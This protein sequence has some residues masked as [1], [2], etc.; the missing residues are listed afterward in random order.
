[1]TQFA[2]LSNRILI[3][4]PDFP[5]RWIPLVHLYD[6]DLPLFPISYFHVL[7]SGLRKDQRPA[8]FDRGY[9]FIEALRVNPHGGAD[10]LVVTNVAPSDQNYEELF[11][12]IVEEVH[13]RLGL[14][15]PV[16]EA[17]VASAFSGPLSDRNGVL[18][19]LWNRVVARAYGG[20]LPFGRTWDPVLGLAR[21]VASWY[22][23]G[24][25][26][27]E[28]IQTHYFASR[29][30]ER[31]QTQSAMPAVDF[32]LLPTW[33]ELSS[34]DLSL[35]SGFPKFLALAEGASALVGSTA[36]SAFGTVVLEP[37]LKFTRMKRRLGRGAFSSDAFLELARTLPTGRLRNAVIECFNAFDKG[38]GRPLKFLMMLEDLRLQRY[39]PE[40][41][42]SDDLASI[43]QGLEGTYNSPK[44]IAIFAQQCFANVN[45][46]PLDTWVNTFLQYPLAIRGALSDKDAIRQL[47]S[48]GRRLG[49][50]ERLIW[51]AAQARKVHSSACDDALWCIKRAGENARGANPL[52]CA[53]CLESVRSVC[54]AFS[55]IATG[56]VSFNSPR[57]AATFNVSTTK[58]EDSPQVFLDVRGKSAGSL[59][60]DAVTPSDAGHLL[61][62]YPRADHAS[63][64]LTVREFIRRYRV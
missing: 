41:F 47:F 50:V 55:G 9:G 14:S 19:Q 28:L 63:E 8:A 29:F 61:H 53:V 26:K 20:S 42:T 11:A 62:Q 3:H 24:G 12:K 21:W 43:Y 27:S 49:K 7:R 52:S 64:P 13:E 44:A 46:L 18:V 40:D 54:P 58:N 57:S 38:P 60:N 22:A 35:L 48:N 4:I 36:S 1:M 31:V 56:T 17:D 6:P 39:S 51:F 10:A 45:A 30:G 33:Q 2:P 34:G 37:H 16:I 5:L 23:P 15:D 59:I 25:R 32:F